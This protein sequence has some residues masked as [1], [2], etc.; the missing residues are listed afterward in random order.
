MLLAKYY[1]LPNK[2]PDAN[3]NNWSE[4]LPS[5]LKWRQENVRGDYNLTPRNVIMGRY[6]QD[7]W[8][9]PSYNGN[10]YWGDSPFPTVN[11]S[12]AQPSKQ[13]IGRVTSTIS[14]TLVNDAEFAY[15]NNR[16]NI[17]PGGTDPGLIA[18][19]NTAI[20]TLYPTSLKNN[21]TGSIP[22]IW[23][24]LQQYG[25][26]ANIWTIA[27]WNNK[28]DIYTVRDDVSKVLGNHIVKAGFFLGWNAKDEDT[29][30]RRSRRHP[31]SS[32]ADN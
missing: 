25:N 3:K 12:W 22:T 4:S 9:N 32:S 24:G 17:S 31:N 6:V 21:K 16:I 15:S 14:N 11:S 28:L 23:G 7:N 27:P 2:T 19:L 13:I 1:P 8:T 20:P 30:F 26:Q 5:S 10:Q 18:Q 29:S